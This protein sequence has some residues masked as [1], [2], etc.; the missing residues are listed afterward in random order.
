HISR[1]LGGYRVAFIGAWLKIVSYTGA[2]AF[3]AG[4][5]ADY[6]IEFSGGLLH[7]E[8]HRLPLA[9]GGLLFFYLVHVVGVRWFGRL[10][11]TMCALL[12]VSLL[13]LVAPGLFAIHLS[14]YQP[15]VT[16]GFGGFAASLLPIFFSYARFEALAQTAGE[17][18]DST[19]RL[20]R[21]FLF[22]ITATAGIFLLMSA[23]S[24][25]VLP[26]A[27]LQASN[28][29]MSAVASVYLMSGGVKFVTLGA[30]MA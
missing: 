25:G 7:S 1:T 20:P 14:N 13:V 21:V 12:G 6:L 27:S 11:V 28:A 19:N 2:E 24:F 18:Q 29:P 30:I 3:L 4:A 16:H 10:Q 23:V 17:V 9:L 8:T 15:F 26:G 22:G 5:L